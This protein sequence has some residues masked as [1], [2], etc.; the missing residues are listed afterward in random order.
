MNKMEEKCTS[1]SSRKKKRKSNRGSHT[2]YNDEDLW[3]DSNEDDYGLCKVFLLSGRH[4]TGKSALVHAAANQAGCVLV[5]IN[6][7]EKRG[8]SALKRAIEECTQSHSSLALLKRGTNPAFRSFGAQ[9]E[10][11]SLDVLSDSVDE[12]ESDDDGAEKKDVGD[13]GRLAIIL[14][15][16]GMYTPHLF[17]SCVSYA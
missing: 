11:S 7:T 5:E 9:A 10:E 3:Y 2:Y 17:L 1:L 6:T 8:G 4:G 15:D 13:R 12:S 16:E 14:I